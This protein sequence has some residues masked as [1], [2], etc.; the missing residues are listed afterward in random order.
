M[1]GRSTSETM[2][3]PDPS[4][5]PRLDPLVIAVEIGSI[6]L[7]VLLAF[8]VNEWRDS[9]AAAGRVKAVKEA[10]RQEV[11]RNRQVLV[12]RLSYHE[13][14]RDSVWAQRRRFNQETF[15]LRP[16]E[17]LP[18]LGDMGFENG[19]ATV[20]DLSR[21]GWE[22]ALATDVLTYMDVDEV[23]FLSTVY[24][25]QTMV[26]ETADRLL[27]G[28]GGY[29][30]AIFTGDEPALGLQGFGATLTDIVLRQQEQIALYDSLLAVLPEHLD[31][32]R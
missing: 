20:V 28:L 25:R 3:P 6:V 15:T 16:G 19:L 5:K 7:A 14:M 13:A 9:R 31:L 2:P 30:N 26:N 4:S 17:R 22:T 18:A 10:M 29:R 24:A 27:D 1:P 11:E 32:G 12:A 21:S 8:A 23:S